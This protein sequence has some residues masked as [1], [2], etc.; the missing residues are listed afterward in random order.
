VTE[1][2]P[3]A[4]DALAPTP[5][6]TAKAYAAFLDY[7]QMGPGRSLKKLCERYR[8][9]TAGEVGVKNPP[10]QRLAT[11]ETWSTRFQWQARLAAY[12]T[13]RQQRALAVWEQRQAEVRAAD[14]EA[15]DALR[16]LAAD[17]LAETPQFLKTTRRM[18]KGEQGQPVREVIT[19]GLDARLILEALGLASKLQRQAAEV[20]P[21][22]Q[23]HE[24][25]GQGGGAIR[26]T[27]LS[28]LP[29]MTP[30]MAAAA[31]AALQAALEAADEQANGS[32]SEPTSA[33]D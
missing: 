5:G 10:T 13:E 28:V 31:L 30:N 18:V 22:A 25:T 33:P 8:G 6:E 21:V 26:V 20:A 29:E 32:S 2:D 27:D 7:V 24:H 16:K 17:I 1:F 12:E 15:G 14:W 23:R 9:Q 4:W 3:A 11:L 19:I